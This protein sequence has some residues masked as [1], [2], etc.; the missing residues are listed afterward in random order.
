[1]RVKNTIECRPRSVT[2][3]RRE[4]RRQGGGPEAGRKKLPGGKTERGSGRRRARGR[5]LVN[6]QAPPSPPLPLHP[7]LPCPMGFALFFRGNVVGTKKPVESRWTTYVAR[8]QE[9]GEGRRCVR[10]QNSSDDRWRWWLMTDARCPANGAISF[11]GI[12]RADYRRLAVNCRRDGFRTARRG[13]G[14]DI[15]RGGRE[16]GRERGVSLRISRRDAEMH[17]KRAR[18]ISQLR[19]TERKLRRSGFPG[20][21]RESR[22]QLARLGTFAWR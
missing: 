1:M 14:A 22:S 3:P 16:R 13:S 5:L 8:T 2:L 11:V 12:F 17:V 7:S 10:S 21:M 18:R 6:H 15:S 19:Q 20:F 9:R 4:R